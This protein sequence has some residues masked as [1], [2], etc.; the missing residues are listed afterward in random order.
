MKIPNKYQVYKVRLDRNNIK[1]LNIQAFIADRLYSSFIIWVACL[2]GATAAMTN[3]NITILILIYILLSY[4][5]I[6]F[7]SSRLN[8]KEGQY[9]YIILNLL[10]LTIFMYM[11]VLVNWLLI[12]I[13]FTIILATLSYTFF[14]YD[15]TL[16]KKKEL[17]K[18]LGIIIGLIVS[19]IALKIGENVNISLLIL[20]TGGVLISSYLFFEINYV[21]KNAES[22]AK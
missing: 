21:K 12:P 8:I 4:A 17:S 19:I 11:F 7:A 2:F 15:D 22:V 20:L 6:K 14:K 1:N 3:I 13:L 10:P 5:A 16:N 18:E 9:L